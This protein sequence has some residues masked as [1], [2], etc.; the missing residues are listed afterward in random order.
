MIKTQKQPF[1]IPVFIPHAGCPHQCVF[2]NQAAVTGVKRRIISPEHLRI[3]IRGYL[4]YNE[5]QLKPVQIAYYGGNFLGLQNDDILMLL[6]EADQFVKAGTVDSIRFST[7]PDT[8]TRERL[9]IISRFPVS[10]VEIGVQSMNDAV[11]A[12]SGR[13][14]TASDT[15]KAAK[16]LKERGYRLGMQMMVA[17]PGSDEDKDI[18]SARSIASLSPD[19]VRIYPTAV[20]K[21]SLLARWHGD[22]KYEPLSLES[23]VTLVKKIYLLFREK[24]IPV[25]RMGL[26]ASEDLDK[27]I[28]LVA[29]P[30]H[31][32]FGHLVF[33]EI[34][35]DMASALL[36]KAGDIHTKSLILKVHPRSISKMRGLRNRNIEIL[37]SEF[38]PDSVNVVADPSV[39]EEEVNADFV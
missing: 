34:F 4:R 26:Q 1:I 5:Q 12:A 2:C 33:S 7:R 22:G 8:V 18:A 21:D 11:L 24:N 36:R 6:R 13:G 20:L 31:P 9:N 29:G 14:H 30:Y 38:H 3:L 23:C 37:K 10:T 16:H 35:L 15:E 19:F 17:L 32:A 25:I 27:G 39:G 28:S